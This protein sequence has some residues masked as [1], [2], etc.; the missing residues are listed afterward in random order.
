MKILFLCKSNV[1]R[2]QMAEA[3]FNHLNKNMNIKAESAALLMPQEK[4]HKLVARVMAERGIDISRNKSKKVTDEMIK[5]ANRI[6]LMNPDLLGLSEKFQI[7]G[8][9]IEVW[10]V[11]DVVANENQENLERFRRARN[12]IEEKIRWMV[13]R[14]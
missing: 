6:I 9:K 10:N 5:N 7:P 14:F 12:L 4:M 13:Y 2:S 11:P 1:T 8:E 3:F